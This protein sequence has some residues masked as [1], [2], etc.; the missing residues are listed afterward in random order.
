VS[1][2]SIVVPVYH[3]A[4]SL[5]DL[6]ARFQALAARNPGDTF[7]FV[8]VDDGSRDNSFQVLEGLAG[9]DARVR[10][11]K[12]S[13]NFG[14]NPALLAGL[15]QARGD[16]VA[17]IAA[18]LQDPPELIHDMLA[19]WRQG[20]KVVLAA[21]EGRDDPGMTSLLANT[22]YRA[23]RRFAIKN[24][25]EKGF[26][27]FLIDRQVCELVNGIQ[28]NNVYLMG[29]I[30]WLGFDPAVIHYRRREREKRY[31][32][33]MWGFWRKVKYFL[34]AF[35][36]FS[37]LP[38]RATSLIGFVVAT[39][40]GLYAVLVIA[41]RLTTGFEPEGWT[42]LMVVVLVIGG[43]QM[44]MI[45]SL[46]EYMWR[47]LDETRR[48]PRFIIERVIE[49]A[50]PQVSAPDAPRSAEQQPTTVAAGADGRPGDAA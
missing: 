7:E 8:F 27:F 47:N 50:P 33:S 43:V 40:G 20:K 19:M 35:V 17:A 26:D 29:L 39:L 28:E 48:R 36:A 11:I 3:N 31:G 24:M 16:V 49:P 30:L 14:S 18:D 46:G 41:L 15:D 44:L 22:F 5:P 45:G 21:R 32:R 13:R 25:P 42:S 9:T 34:D 4:A 6:L 12:L 1:L 37:Y 10:V 2:V 23:F 38:I